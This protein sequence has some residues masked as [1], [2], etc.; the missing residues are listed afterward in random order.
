MSKAA[1]VV[2]FER[3][4]LRD[5]IE[6]IEGRGPGARGVVAVLVDDAGHG[7]FR[8]SGSLAQTMYF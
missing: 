6:A 7:H 2:R 1:K 8:I 4:S 3:Q 5:L